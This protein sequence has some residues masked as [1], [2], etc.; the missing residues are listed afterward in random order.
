MVRRSKKALGSG[1]QEYFNE[2]RPVNLR[3]DGP[4]RLAEL[5]PRSGGM[6]TNTGRHRGLVRGLANPEVK[7][8]NAQPHLRRVSRLAPVSK[9]VLHLLSHSLQLPFFPDRFRQ[10]RSST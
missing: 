6:P 8:R 7:F 9:V 1:G 5:S 4:A 2:K 3:V 10:R